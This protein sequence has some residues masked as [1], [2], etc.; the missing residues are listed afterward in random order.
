M[1]VAKYKW[2]RKDSGQAGMP[3]NGHEAAFMAGT[4]P[5]Y[6]TG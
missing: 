3:E 2:N 4:E 6:K 5:F 1:H